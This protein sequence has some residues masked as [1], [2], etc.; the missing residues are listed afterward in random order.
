[1]TTLSH[2]NV[3]VMPGGLNRRLR[4]VYWQLDGLM[5]PKQVLVHKRSLSN[6]LSA[7][8][9]RVFYEKQTMLPPAVPTAGYIDIALS[10]FKRLLLK[11]RKPATPMTIKQFVESYVGR[12]RRIYEAAARTYIRD[13]VQQRDSV[14]KIFVK[15]E[16]IL[17]TGERV[18]P[19]LISPR[20]PV[21]NVGLGLYIKP[22]EYRIYHRIQKVFE[23]IFEVETPVIAKGFNAEQTAAIICRKFDRFTR[24]NVIGLDASRFDQHV[25]LEMLQWEHSIY[26]RY[27]PGEWELSRLLKM[28]LHNT[29]IG[30][31]PEGTVHMRIDGTRATG[32][33]NTALGNCLISAAMIFSYAALC[34]IMKFD[35]FLNG[36][37]VICFMEE[38]CTSAFVAGLPKF[39]MDL[40]FRMKVESPVRIM[41]NIEFCQNHPIFDG[42]GWV[43]VRKFPDCISK[44]STI[45]HHVFAGDGWKDYLASV[46]ECGLS[47]CGGI[48][49]LE[50]YYQKLA[51]MGT[52]RR[53]YLEFISSGFLQM[54]RGMNR[55][56]GI[57]AESRNSFDI[58]YN[59]S[60][61]LQVALENRIRTWTTGTE[62]T[63]CDPGSLDM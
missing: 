6:L 62:F 27:Y 17:E 30:D 52:S 37:D 8:M 21:Y 18:V 16:K 49:I 40:G 36:D 60:P 26:E 51:S 25:C 3:R 10:Q 7:I 13:G 28:Q 32:D 9:E 59:I 35:C 12:K 54:T 23:G 14:L 22:L 39:Y 55:S 19:R 61:D 46:G 48:P 1:M 47:L 44:D 29:G 42:K 20:S 11:H 24:P 57:T 5:G 15:F 43:M 38:E 31:T 33:M 50:A 56:C 63:F 58:A 41:E 34:G 53:Q 2:S 4:E 45:I